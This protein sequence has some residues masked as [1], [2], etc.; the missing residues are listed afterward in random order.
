MTILDDIIAYK[1]LEVAETK[2]AASFGALQEIIRDQAAPRRF[3][4]SLRRRMADGIA[5]IAEIKKASPSKGLIRADFDP[6]ALA[7][8]YFDG[9][10]ACLSVLTDK[11]SFQGSRE[12]LRMARGATTLPILRKD[13]MIDPYQIVEARAL[14]ADCILLIV[15][16][17]SDAQLSELAAAADELDL[18]ILIETHDEFE[19]DRAL[20][21]GSG[22]I[23]INNRNLKTFATDLATTER[24]AGRIPKDRLIVAESGIN[25]YPDIARL[26]AAGAS[27]F[28]VGESL[29]R[30]PDIRLA[31]AN[32][33]KGPSNT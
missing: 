8:A 7:L 22:M 31:T 9:G 20:K 14:G 25:A 17:L 11:P 24:L 10:A 26:R 12:H 5:L 6:K 21:C 28:L 29:M 4:R 30:Q 16:C 32:L 13:F 15:A 2:M 27:A 1:K 3:E 23:G 18:D 33:L 19:I